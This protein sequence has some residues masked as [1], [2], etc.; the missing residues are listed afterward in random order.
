MRGSDGV[1]LVWEEVSVHYGSHR[2]VDEVS[3]SVRSGELVALTGPNGSG[4]STLLS[5]AAGVRE[6]DAGRVL[7][8]GLERRAD[9]VAY[10]RQVGWSSQQSGLYEELTVE[11]NLRFFG[12]LQGLN[13]SRLHQNVQRV[14]GL[15]GLGSRRHQ[16][17]GTLSGGWKQRLNIAVALVH[18]PPVLLLDEPTSGLD[19]E[20]RERLLTDIARLR[21]EGCAIVLA[22]HYT[23]DVVAVADRVVQLHHGRLWELTA[24]QPGPFP[25]S[26]PLLLYGQLRH[27]PLRFVLRL[28]RQRL[29]DGVELELIGRRLRL[30]AETAETLGYALSELLREGVPFESYRSVTSSATRQA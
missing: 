11:E 23:E 22:T 15:F 18:N 3:L 2:A 10:A 20:S 26:Q 13:G 17:V 24:D 19:A 28:V 21:E 14:A 27:P 4:K 12:R 9:P 7:V 1:V 16:R 8:R 29:P 6:A 25:I 30:R 5:V